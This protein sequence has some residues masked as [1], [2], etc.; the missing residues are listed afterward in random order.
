MSRTTG[1]RGKLPVNHHYRQRGASRTSLMGLGNS[2]KY[3]LE[4]NVQA[5]GRKQSF[6]ALLL[7]T[8]HR[9]QY[10]ETFVP[11][12]IRFCGNH[13]DLLKQPVR[14]SRLGINASGRRPTNVRF[15]GAGILPSTV[16]A[17]S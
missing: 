9:I 13:L 17:R 7:H 2:T 10:T 14:S 5:T 6:A 15:L 12:H 3:L 4:S 11:G 8:A 16:P 1:L